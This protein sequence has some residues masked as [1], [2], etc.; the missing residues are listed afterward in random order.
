[1]AN[2]FIGP[3]KSEQ[4]EKIAS[5]EATFM[6]QPLET[7]KYMQKATR[8]EVEGVLSDSAEKPRPFKFEYDNKIVT[9]ACSDKSRACDVSLEVPFGKEGTPSTDM[10]RAYAVSIPLGENYANV[11]NIVEKLQ[12]LPM[13]HKSVVT[14]LNKF[15]LN[16][17]TMVEPLIAN[18]LIE[19][20]NS[21][22]LRPR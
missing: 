15:R 8:Q 18:E 9:I 19:L 17:R 20:A 6:G 5:D 13:W 22:V 3:L 7:A 12:P 2:S 10:H 4:K 16:D 14:R 1:M 21:N 11:K